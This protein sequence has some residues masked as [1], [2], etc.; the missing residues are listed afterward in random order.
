MDLG[1]VAGID[2][3]TVRIGIAISDPERRL[4]SPHENYVRRGPRQ[5]AEHFRRLVH[6]EQVKLFVVGLP[7]HLDGRESPKSHEAREFGVWLAQSTGVPVEFFDERFTS[8]EAET[9]LLEAG[10]S[11][12]R[13]KKRRDMLAAQIMLSAFLESHARRQLPPDALDDPPR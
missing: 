7:I 6:E 1:R 11:R 5:D 3:G 4:A 2:Y 9:V 12:K 8:V 13:R 10:L